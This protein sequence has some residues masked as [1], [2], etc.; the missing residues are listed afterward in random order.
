M[1]GSDSFLTIHKKKG[2]KNVVKPFAK[3]KG[4]QII[5]EDLELDLNSRPENKKV[6]SK[7]SKGARPKG[8]VSGQRKTSFDTQ[9]TAEAFSPLRLLG[10]LN[11]QLPQTVRE[12][13]D[14]PALRNRTGRFASSVIATDVITTPQGFQSIGYTYQKD[15]YQTFEMG[16]AKGSPD[17]DPRTLIDRSIREI[18]AEFALGRLYTRR[19]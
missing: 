15:P 1:P 10:T 14:L 12:N 16:Y 18:A 19:V 8:K 6:S 9:K 17:R 3:I 7:V 2:L 11:K 13:M 5:T 4:I